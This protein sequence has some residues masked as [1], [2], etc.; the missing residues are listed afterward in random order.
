MK[1]IITH[2]LA[3]LAL[4]AS[5][6]AAAIEPGEVREYGDVV[7]ISAEAVRPDRIELRWEIAEDYYLYNNRFL[8]FSTET[9]GVVLAEHVGDFV[10]SQLACV[11]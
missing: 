5:T 3:G 8:R 1:R 9:E 4:F 2:W 7:A 11:A 6:A 10:R